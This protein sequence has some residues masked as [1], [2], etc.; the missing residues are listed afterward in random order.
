M[1]SFVIASASA[2]T[3]GVWADI[4]IP[5]AGV[6]EEWTLLLDVADTMTVTCTTC[7]YANY[8]TFSAFSPALAPASAGPVKATATGLTTAVA[9]KDIIRFN[10]S[11]AGGTA[12]RLSLNLWIRKT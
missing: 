7:T 6:L 1:V 2:L 5:S 12:K 3:T 9:A 4:Q 8:D 10:L 11:T